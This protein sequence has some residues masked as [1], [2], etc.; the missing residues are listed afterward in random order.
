M[1]KRRQNITQK[2]TILG[3]GGCL[4]LLG[5]C[6]SPYNNS[7]DCPYGQGLGCTSMSTVNK[8][9]DTQRLDIQADLMGTGNNQGKRVFV[10][11]G[12]DRPSRLVRVEQE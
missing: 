3:M 12:E 7:F 5:G 2:M 9:I 8:I 6:S 10:Y 4:L 1:N 11:F